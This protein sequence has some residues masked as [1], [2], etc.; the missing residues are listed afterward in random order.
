MNQFLKNCLAWSKK[1][2]LIWMSRK[3]SFSISNISYKE[4]NTYEPGNMN[5]LISSPHGGDLAPTDIPDRQ[6]VTDEGVI[7]KDYA[8]D[9]DANTKNMAKAI[10]DA[11][12]LLFKERNNIDARPHL[13]NTNLRRHVLLN[14]I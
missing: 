4:Y 14:L 13:L 10:R 5:I 1:R 3:N 12:V 11:L 9:N 8:I 7:L 2:N 6:S